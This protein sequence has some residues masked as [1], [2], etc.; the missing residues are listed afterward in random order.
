MQKSVRVFSE[1]ILL[2][3]AAPHW[4]N[5]FCAVFLLGSLLL[6]VLAPGAVAMSRTDIQQAAG[7]EGLSSDV[8]DFLNGVLED[9]M[10]RAVN[11]AP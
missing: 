1:Q 4:L 10:L 5:R 3:H 6:G 11:V 9:A 8:Q 2:M 7:Q